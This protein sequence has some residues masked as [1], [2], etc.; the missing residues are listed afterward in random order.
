MLRNNL[1]RIVIMSEKTKSISSKCIK[2]IMLGNSILPKQHKMY[3][4]QSIFYWESLFRTARENHGC[5][6]T[7]KHSFYQMWV[8]YLLIILERFDYRKVIS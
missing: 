7:S 1:Q 2:R 8:Y 6:D 4:F 5:I 3:T